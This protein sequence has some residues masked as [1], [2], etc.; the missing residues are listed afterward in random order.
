MFE[1]FGVKELQ[2]P[3]KHNENFDVS[4]Q[5]K[6]CVE[7]MPDYILAKEMVITNQLDIFTA[8]ETWLDSYTDVEVEFPGF[9]IYRLDREN[10]PGAMSSPSKTLKLSVYQ[11][12]PTSLNLDCICYG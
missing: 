7:R 9:N 4:S 10:K 12:Y 3:V 1:C 8:S 5:R 6:P 11:T 2:L